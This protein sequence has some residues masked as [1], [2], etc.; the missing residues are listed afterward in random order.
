M[1]EVTAAYAR[2]AWFDL[3]TMNDFPVLANRTVSRH[4][5]RRQ[6]GWFSHT[7]YR[8]SDDADGLAPFVALGATARDVCLFGCLLSRAHR[9]CSG[10]KA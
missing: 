10:R 4:G 6:L 8:S 7:P 3:V 1:G 2:I 5:Q 9:D